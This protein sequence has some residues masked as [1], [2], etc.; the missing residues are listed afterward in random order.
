MYIRDMKHEEKMMRDHGLC[1]TKFLDE[2]YVLSNTMRREFCGSALAYIAAD[3]MVYPCTY[4]ASTSK[5]PAGNLRQQSFKELW[6]TS[7][8]DIRSITFDDFKGCRSCELSKAPY[9]CTSRCPIMSEV[10]T[11]DPLQCGSTPYLQQSL[12]RKTELI[13]EHG[14]KLG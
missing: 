6:E 8:Q 2:C 5:Y 12:R 14:I 10:Y 4:C 1:V 13:L 7:F 9:F 11:G 3:G